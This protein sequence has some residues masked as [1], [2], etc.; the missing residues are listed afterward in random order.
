[1]RTV[2]PVLE[3]VGHRQQLDRPAGRSNASAAA[4]LPRPP[5]PI[6]ARRIVLS[7]AACTRG[8]A[9]A[10]SAEPA[11]SLPLHCKNSRRE[12]CDTPTCEDWGVVIHGCP[13]CCCCGYVGNGISPGLFSLRRENRRVKSGQRQTAKAI[14]VVPG[15]RHEVEAAGMAFKSC[16][17]WPRRP[18]RRQAPWWRADCGPRF[19]LKTSFHAGKT[20]ATTYQLRLGK[21]SS[22]GLPVPFPF[23]RW[24]RSGKMS[25]ACRESETLSARRLAMEGKRGTVHERWV[26]RTEAAYRRMFEGKRQ[27]ELVT[28]TQ[29]EHGG[30]DRQG[31]GRVSARGADSFGSGGETDGGFGDVLSEMRPSGNVGGGEGPGVAGADGDDAC[32]RH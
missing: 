4:P 21:S 23:L 5:Q 32:W 14:A 25:R 19:W 1:M 9:T 6:S 27:E 11:A 20:G 26:Q 13:F 28:L 18:P 31:T 30:V 3:E 15:R 17:P 29:R 7:S 8:I 16:R 2:Q 10:A 24:P 12:D 22:H